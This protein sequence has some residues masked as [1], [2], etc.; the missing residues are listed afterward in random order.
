MVKHPRRH[1]LLTQ[2]EDKEDYLVK[3]GE[4]SNPA[5]NRTA[6]LLT[7]LP[8]AGPSDIKPLFSTKK[9]IVVAASLGRD[10]S[11]RADT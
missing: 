7:N 1:K 2:S 9:C 8:T 3:Y 10:N 11:V 5:Y 4:D 6:M